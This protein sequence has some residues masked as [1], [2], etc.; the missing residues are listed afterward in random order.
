M[1]RECQLSVKVKQDGSQNAA[2]QV[3]TGD[4][5]LGRHITGEADSLRVISDE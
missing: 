5:R 1:E 2:L 4:S 3:K